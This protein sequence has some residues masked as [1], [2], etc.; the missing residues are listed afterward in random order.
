V[1]RIT[2]FFSCIYVFGHNFSLVRLCDGDFG[3]TPVDDITAGIT[4]VTF[5][6]AFIIIIIIIIIIITV[7]TYRL[8]QPL[9]D[10]IHERINKHH[11]KLEAHPTPLLQS[12]LQPVNT[13]R[14]KQCWPLDLQGT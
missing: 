11:N 14:L 7:C 5:C 1:K 3:I 10:I 9:R 4:C 13:R 2:D 8:Q 6:F 12:P